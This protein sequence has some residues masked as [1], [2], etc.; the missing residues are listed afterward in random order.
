MDIFTEHTRAALPV[1][2]AW[3]Y[4]E[5]AHQQACSP[6]RAASVRHRTFAVPPRGAPWTGGGPT[7]AL[8]K[9]RLRER[10]DD[11]VPD[12][13]VH[14]ADVRGYLETATATNGFHDRPVEMSLVDAIPR[15]ALGKAPLVRRSSPLVAAAGRTSGTHP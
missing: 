11:T 5:V 10:F 14:L 2:V 6:C 9:V 1:H 13:D 4:S 12:R 15:S 3:S 7:E 8:T